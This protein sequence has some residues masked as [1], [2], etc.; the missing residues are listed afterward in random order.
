MS[1]PG[2]GGVR[3]DLPA[4]VQGTHRS[5]HVPPF[6]PCMTPPQPRQRKVP[7]QRFF[8]EEM[9]LPVALR[10]NMTDYSCRFEVGPSATTA[11]RPCHSC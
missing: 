11:Q 10:P 3:T 4:R 2:G 6:D 1:F 7:T 5:M 8:L 9:G